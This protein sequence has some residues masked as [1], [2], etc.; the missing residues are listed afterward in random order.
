MNH[1]L[2]NTLNELRL[3][4]WKPLSARLGREDAGVL[5]KSISIEFKTGGV[6]IVFNK[7]LSRLRERYYRDTLLEVLKR[8]PDRR[9]TIRA[10]IS[11]IFS[12]EHS[13]GHQSYSEVPEQLSPPQLG[14][15]IL[16]IVL[17]TKEERLN[18]PGDLEEEYRGIAAKYGERYARLWY[19]KQVAASAWPMV[20]KMIRWGVLTWVAE[21]VRRRI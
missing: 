15:R 17:R 7:K 8:E 2:N 21:F 6:E 16:L 9:I 1:E 4:L 10:H 12:L 20:R 14:E 19:Y 5:L 11:D 18:I 13:Q 3:H